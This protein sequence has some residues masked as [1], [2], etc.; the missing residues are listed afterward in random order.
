MLTWADDLRRYDVA[1]LTIHEC[2]LASAKLR[3]ELA[4][5]ERQSVSI[6]E[7]MGERL[8][9]LA[10]RIRDLKAD[11]QSHRVAQIRGQLAQLQTPDE[12]RAALLTELAQLESTASAS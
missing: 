1:A 6:P 4:E 2:V 3:T 10:R 11:M 8:T 9:L 5:Y 12:R 7:W